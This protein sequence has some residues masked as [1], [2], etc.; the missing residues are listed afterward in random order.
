MSD[1][2]N[3]LGIKGPCI[4]GNVSHGVLMENYGES[5]I[6]SSYYYACQTYVKNLDILM[7]FYELDLSPSPAP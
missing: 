5:A 2:H 7:D 3:A 4:E 1:R 6:Y